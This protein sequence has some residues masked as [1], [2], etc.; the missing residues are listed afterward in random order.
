MIFLF[1][2]MECKM[3]RYAFVEIL[4]FWGQEDIISCKLNWISPF[5]PA[6]V[7]FANQQKVLTRSKKSLFMAISI[8]HQ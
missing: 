4:G 7:S 2:N 6:L 1:H 5:V 3:I 8:Q